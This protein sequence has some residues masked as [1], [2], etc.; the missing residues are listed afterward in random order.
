MKRASFF[1]HTDCEYFPC[2]K[3]VSPARFNCLFCYCPLYALG[4][5]CGGDVTYTDGGVK[6]CSHCGLPHDRENYERILGRFPDIVKM[7]REN[8]E[9]MGGGA[10]E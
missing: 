9:G 1:Q 5:R 3:S 4:S 10:C 7:M 6:D 2:H 8:R